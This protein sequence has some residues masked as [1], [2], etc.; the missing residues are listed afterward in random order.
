MPGLRVVR[1]NCRPYDARDYSC[2][3][4]FVDTAAGDTRVYFDVVTISR[5][6]G[7]WD[8]KSGLCLH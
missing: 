3:V 8:L 6:D 2:T 5:V 1:A 7:G 4:D